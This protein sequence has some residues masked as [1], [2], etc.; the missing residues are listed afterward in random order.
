M[1]GIASLE[2]NQGK[3]LAELRDPAGEHVPML[4]ALLTTSCMLE[5]SKLGTARLDLPTYV[6]AL[7]QVLSQFAPMERCAIRVESDDLPALR[8]SSGVL[9]PAEDDALMAAALAGTPVAVGAMAGAPLVVDG[10]TVGYLAVQ[11]LPTPL[12]EARLVP[13]SCELLGASFGAQFEAERLRRKAALARVMELAASLDETYGELELVDLVAAMAALP[14]TVGA[15]LRLED[16]RLAGPVD[17]QSGVED[18][19]CQLLKEVDA[20]RIRVEFALRLTSNPSADD[21]ARAEEVAAALQSALARI[22]R[23]RKLQEEAETDPLTGIGNRRRASRALAQ[24]WNWTERKRGQMAVLIVDLDH[25]KKVNDSLG[26][27]VGDEVL[28]AVART[29]AEAVRGYDTAARW[30]GE[31]FL[32]VCPDT[33]AAGAQALSRRLRQG[34]P[35]ACGE[36]LPEGWYQS[37]SIGIAIGP[38]HADG[39]QPLIA[40]ADR[41]LYN[42]KAAG[43]DQVALAG[44]N[45][46]PVPAGKGAPLRRR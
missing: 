35:L 28:K 36:F 45:G 39:V 13:Q 20:G 29:I 7:V 26:H 25:F 11:G 37:C 34:I 31:E 5:L 19:P 30:G 9:D 23:S 27:G 22:D 8:A 43:R 40:M 33:D 10:V 44:P 32:I 3:L 18:T 46:A 4:T 38:D 24:A 6:N 12:V 42:A 21:E 16:N 17:V 14:K 2:R 1:N 15:A 41:A